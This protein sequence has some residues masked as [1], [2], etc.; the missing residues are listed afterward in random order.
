MAFAVIISN[1]TQRLL[2]RAADAASELRS[3]SVDSFTD[4][5]REAYGSRGARAVQ[6]AVGVSQV[7]ICAGYMVFS[8][9]LLQSATP[10]RVSEELLVALQCIALIPIL[11]LPGPRHLAWASIFGC[12]AF[13]LGFVTIFYHGFT[14]PWV[15]P[16][17]VDFI[18]PD[19]IS[20]ATGPLLF[21]F[22]SHSLVFPILKSMTH[23]ERFVP[24]LNWSMALISI[25]LTG[26]ALFGWFL[27]G[28]NMRSI[29]INNLVEHEIT[30]Q[31]VKGALV[32]DTMLTYPLALWPLVVILEDSTQLADQIAQSPAPHPEHRHT[33]PNVSARHDT[34]P[35]HR[36]SYP[37]PSPRM[38]GRGS[39][40]SDDDLA[41]SRKSSYPIVRTASSGASSHGGR[42]SPIMGGTAFNPFKPLV[43]DP[44][45]PE[46]WFGARTKRRMLRAALVG[47][48]ALISLQFRSFGAYLSL[49][50]PAVIGFYTFILPVAFY[51]KIAKPKLSSW[52]IFGH[53]LLIIIG[54]SIMVAGS[55]SGWAHVVRLR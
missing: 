44:P 32:L 39:D 10:E 34:G 33:S 3:V 18:R 24:I 21:L 53:W 52:S 28:D 49:F 46:S 16:E 38:D 27:F 50:G 31:L 54:A 48:T 9:S 43:L 51:L 30:I 6:I 1:Y 25:A 35:P 12:A 55:W 5:G 11:W 4:L 14:H 15:K 26:F 36:P 8:T 20:L 45:P 2:I 23:R 41:F 42:Q 17:T 7:G 22:G 37:P 19:T 40:T 47:F 29:I 13:M